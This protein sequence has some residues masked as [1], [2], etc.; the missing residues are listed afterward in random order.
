[1]NVLNPKIEKYENWITEQKNKTV[2]ID[3]QIKIEVKQKRKVI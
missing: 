3:I 2:K 1:M